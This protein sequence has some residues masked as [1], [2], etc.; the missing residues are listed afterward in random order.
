MFT[1]D[2]HDALSVAHEHAR[3]LR[4]DTAARRLRLAMASRCPLAAYLRRAR[5]RRNPAL[6]AELREI[7]K[8]VRGDHQALVALALN[9]GGAR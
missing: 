7:D 8:P 1:T 6:L 9:G 4:A 5:V 3:R 2:P